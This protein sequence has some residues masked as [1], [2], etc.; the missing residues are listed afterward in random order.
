[1]E[2]PEVQ[3]STPELPESEH[4]QRSGS[5]KRIY[6]RFIGPFGGNPNLTLLL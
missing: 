2:T 6:G 1:M 4:D 5:W 3:G